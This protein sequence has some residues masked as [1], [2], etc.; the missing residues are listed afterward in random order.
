MQPFPILWSFRRCPYAMRARLAI[1]ASGQQVELREILL[2][3]KPESFLA[4]SPKGTVP[5]L[6]TGDAV[7][8]ESR[9]IMLWAL[10]RNDP[11]GWLAMPAEGHNL[12]DQCDGPFKQALDH[13]KYAVRYPDL[14]PVK[15]RENAMVFLRDLNDRLTRTPF[16]TGAHRRL[17]DM[18]ILP[19]VRQFA[20]I[21]RAWFDAQG[22]GPLCRWL[23]HF[24]Q[25]DGFTAVMVKYPPW[26]AGQ[27]RV[28]FG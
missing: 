4:T 17:A 13:T 8:A 25:S 2:R 12:I 27:D 11:D 7:I 14:D 1:R 3:D 10:G 9:D 23:D 26:Q 28:L 18:A 20:N 15:E 6:D 16:L 22:L 5:V 21:D 24:L 19:F